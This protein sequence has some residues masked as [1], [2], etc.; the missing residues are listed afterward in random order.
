[1]NKTDN[2]F[3]RSDTVSANFGNIAVKPA[4]SFPFKYHA[5]INSQLWSY[6]NN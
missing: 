2:K 5:N 1:M 3:L 4:V 6:V